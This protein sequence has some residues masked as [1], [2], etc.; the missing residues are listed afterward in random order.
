MDT[1]PQLMMASSA[2]GYHVGSVF[3]FAIDFESHRAFAMTSFLSR[4]PERALR[5]L[6]NLRLIDRRKG[7]ELI[8]VSTLSQLTARF[9]VDCVFDVGANEGQYATMLRK[10]VGYR[11]DLVS[12]EPLPREQE[13][14]RRR[15]SGDA[16]WHVEDVAIADE[17]GIAQF[18]VAHGSEFSSLSATTEATRNQ[19]SGSA[20]PREVIE[21]RTERLATVFE[22][23]QNRLKF[24][25]PFL[26]LDTQGFDH[27]IIMGGKDVL[28][29]FVGIQTELSVDPLY[30]EATPYLQALGDYE[31]LGFRPCAFFPNNYGHFPHLYEI[32]CVLLRADLLDAAAS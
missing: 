30:D 12:F 28:D 19:F 29:K 27:R 24:R 9:G 31:Q 21:V 10:K 17:D 7:F 18:N 32:D 22:R 6:R 15:A 8:E 16:H 1:A 11:G 2:R 4:L 20:Q 23:L 25:R 26:K 13:V 5:R 14:L 3:S